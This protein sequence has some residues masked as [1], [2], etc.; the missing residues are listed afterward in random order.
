[1]SDTTSRPTGQPDSVPKE[2]T[3]REKFSAE[4]LQKAETDLAQ[5]I[6]AIAKVIVRRA[7]AKARYESELYILIAQ[8]IK[9]SAER[10]IFIRK[11]VSVSR[12]PKR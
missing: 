1:M 12:P 2:P 7:A 9:D 8:E 5:H 3:G 6:G 4:T 10:E 11:A